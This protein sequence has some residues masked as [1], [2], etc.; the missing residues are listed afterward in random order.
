MKGVLACSRRVKNKVFEA[1]FTGERRP[2][3]S[4]TRRSDLGALL[5]ERCQLLGRRMGKARFRFPPETGGS[6]THS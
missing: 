2:K 1:A 5:L 6:P 4:P 3:A